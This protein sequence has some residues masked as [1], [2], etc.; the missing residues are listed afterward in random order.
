MSRL[1]L[2][3]SGQVSVGRELKPRAIAGCAIIDHVLNGELG[4]GG[5]MLKVLEH[6]GVCGPFVVHLCFRWGC[7]GQLV[8]ICNQL[9]MVWR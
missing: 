4:G 2:S 1:L 5:L 9:I 7:T 8:G 3:M 6:G